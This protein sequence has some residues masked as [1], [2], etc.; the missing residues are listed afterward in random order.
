[1]S[2][3]WLKLLPTN[4]L[5]KQNL[6]ESILFV[7][8]EFSQITGNSGARWVFLTQSYVARVQLKSLNAAFTS[9]FI[10]VIVNWFH[11]LKNEVGGRMVGGNLEA[12]VRYNIFR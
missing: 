10:S 12:N 11:C 5:S 1:M 3:N 2:E 7:P 6:K 4:L 8:L 9:R